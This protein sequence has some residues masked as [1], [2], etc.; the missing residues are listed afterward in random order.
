MPFNI[1][2]FWGDS[3]ADSWGELA[4]DPWTEELALT[5]PSPRPPAVDFVY[6]SGYP[7]VVPQ[8][9]PARSDADDLREMVHL[10]SMWTKENQGVAHER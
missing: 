10:Y 3:W 4:A 6:T 1:E 8:H 9:S 7:N 2:R 5:A